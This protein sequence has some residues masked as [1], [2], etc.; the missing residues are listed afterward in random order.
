MESEWKRIGKGTEK[1]RKINFIFTGIKI[2]WNGMELEWKWNRTFPTKKFYAKK[3]W[4]WNGNR[5]VMEL[6]I[7][8]QP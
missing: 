2:C 1:E 7:N 8:G 5:M 4:K 3:E 6:K